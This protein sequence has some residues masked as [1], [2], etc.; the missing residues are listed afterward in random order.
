[1]GLLARFAAVIL[2]TSLAAGGCG[3]DSNGEGLSLAASTTCLER[4]G[5]VDNT[6]DFVA[7]SASQG[8]IRLV[9]DGSEVVISFA[10]DAEEAAELMNSYPPFGP[11]QTERVG[12]AVLAWTDVP[13]DEQAE[14]VSA[15]L[16]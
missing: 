10:T 16:R 13:T 9:T 11:D 5:D 8:A 14:A 6:L 7:E 15:C 3:G 12:N 1:M 2:F 4:L